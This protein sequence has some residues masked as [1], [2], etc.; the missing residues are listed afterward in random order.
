MLYAPHAAT[1]ANAK[2]VI[3]IVATV[4]KCLNLIRWLSLLLAIVIV[5]L[6]N[7]NTHDVTMRHV[8]VRFVSFRFVSFSETF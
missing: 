4:T 2:T 3:I 7:K 8:S 5:I 6:K 1:N